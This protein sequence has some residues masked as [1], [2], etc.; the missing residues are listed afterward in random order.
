METN[1][2]LSFQQTSICSTASLQQLQSVAAVAM[3]PSQC[4][5]TAAASLQQ[6]QNVAAVTMQPLQCLSAAAASL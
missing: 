6:L 3:R 4:V 1:F 2:F 5:S